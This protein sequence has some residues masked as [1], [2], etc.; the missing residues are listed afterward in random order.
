MISRSVLFRIRN[1]SEKSCRENQNRHCMSNNLISKI[2]PVIRLR[3][4]I[5][6]ERTSHRWQY[7][8]C[9][10][11]ECIPKATNAH[12]GCCNTYCYST[13]TLVA[14]ARL[15]ITLQYITYLAYL[16]RQLC[17]HLHSRSQFTRGLRRRSAAACLLRSS[18]RIPRG[19]WKFVCCVC[20]VLSGR[21]LCDELITRPEE[22]YRMWRVVVCDLETS[23]MRRPW[24]AVAPFWYIHTYTHLHRSTY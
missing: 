9:A 6:Q 3:G 24:P 21:G 7:G 4:K 22:S 1:V 15:T 23:W 8:A 11:R 20:C 18:V 5:V 12:S 13:A 2:V 10:M 19:P 14:P 16:H 17:I